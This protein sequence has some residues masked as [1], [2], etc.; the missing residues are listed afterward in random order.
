MNRLSILAAALP[1]AAC[2]MSSPQPPPP[3]YVAARPTAAPLPMGPIVERVRAHYAAV[4]AS[5]DFSGIVR[6][7]AGGRRAYITFGQADYARAIPHEPTTLYSAA[8]ITKG[9]TAASVVALV[10]DGRLSLDDEVGRFLP[11]LADRPMT[12]A[13]VLH[14]R[15]GLP[16][17]LPD[18][19]A[20]TRDIAT[21]LAAHPDTLRPPGEEAYS[22]V[23]YQLMAEVIA[24]AAGRPFEEV[25]REKVLVPAGMGGAML[26]DEEARSLG[27]AMA[28]AAGPGPERMEAAPHSPPMPGAT[29]L[30]ASVDDLARWAEVLADG[31]W[32]ELFA[33]EDPLGSI[34]RRADAIGRY[35]SV[36]GTLPGYGTQAI[37][38][39]E[40]DVA[41]AFAGNLFSF[42]M[43]RLGRDL[44]AL[45]AGE[46]IEPL[47]P[48][49]PE[50]AANATH[51]AMIGRYTHPAFGALDVRETAD[52]LRLSFPDRPAYWDFHLSPVADGRLVWRS[53]GQALRRDAEGR[54]TMAPM[55]GDEE[56]QPLT[57]REGG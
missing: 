26:S 33:P 29:G 52:G 15:A 34:D 27:G 12:I 5:G 40:A 2:A 35:I 22:N 42:P 21:W 50:V 20:G 23:G 53:F 8:S 13:Q 10:R 24:A 54:I 47:A 9:I 44:R 6:I 43:L 11:A 18:E 48:P 25:A 56:G 30:V 16:R 14:H 46:P 57:P 37:D 55:H 51:R 17:D 39:P 45:V 19:D 3:T 1:L 31:G 38:W 36:Q 7:E 28:Y 49:P 4:A 41:I 32:P